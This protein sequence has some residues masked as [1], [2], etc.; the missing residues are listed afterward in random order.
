MSDIDRS[1]G[2]V[3]IVIGSDETEI[4]LFP[5]KAFSVLHGVADLANCAVG[6]TVLR[7]SSSVREADRAEQEEPLGALRADS[8]GVLD[9]LAVLFLALEEGIQEEAGCAGQALELIAF[10][11][12]EAGGVELRAD[13]V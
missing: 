4:L 7:A 13:S 8:I 10:A 1:N 6:A 5:G 9:A 11:G 12:L 3:V 2:E